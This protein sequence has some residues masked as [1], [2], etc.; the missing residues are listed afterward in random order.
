MLLLLGPVF[1]K[2]LSP[3]N[4]IDGAH[5]PVVCTGRAFWAVQAR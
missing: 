3:P 5:T 4:L 2:Q 1:A